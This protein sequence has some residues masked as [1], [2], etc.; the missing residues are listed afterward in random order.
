MKEYSFIHAFPPLPYFI[1]RRR[2]LQ[3][4]HRFWRDRNPRVMTISG[5]GGIGKTALVSQFI[6]RITRGE[7]ERP[8]G[9]FVWSFYAES[10]DD[11]FLHKL[12]DYVTEDKTNINHINLMPLLLDALTSSGHILIILDGLENIQ[13]NQGERYGVLKSSMM[14]HLLHKIA[15]GIGDTQCLITSRYHLNLSNESHQKSVQLNPLSMVESLK[16]L[17]QSDLK[18]SQEDF[19]SLISRSGGHPLTLQLITTYIKSYTDGDIHRANELDFFKD[20]EKLPT[21][22]ILF[23]VLRNVEQD[24]SIQESAILVR[25]SLFRHGATVHDLFTL[26]SQSD[27]SLIAGPLAG[28]EEW[29]ISKI[30]HKLEMLSLLNV[31]SEGLCIV[32]PIVKDYFIRFFQQDE[33][34]NLNNLA[35]ALIP[36]PVSPISPQ[37]TEFILEIIYELTLKRN[38]SLNEIRNLS[39]RLD[40]KE[41]PTVR[42]YSA[43]LDSAL[44]LRPGTPENKN[45]KPTAPQVF[46]SYVRQDQ[47]LV[48]KLR[49]NLE[50]NNIHVWQDIDR[51][52]PG[53]RWK[54]EIRKAIKNGDFFVACFSDNYWSRDRTY[55][56]EELLIAI[57]E[58][59]LRPTDTSWFIPILL[60]PCEVPDKPISN[61]ETLRDL[62][63]IEI[64]HNW[65][66]SIRLLVQIFKK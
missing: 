58:L 38:L 56:N 62:Q 11:V 45:I 57:E 12:Y 60:S 55:M 61:N 7:Y 24:L 25:I 36:A 59:R 51:I 39:N 23:Q 2:E 3:Q 6:N 32:H 1:G 53:R 30:I 5:L 29:E 8:D 16:F 20:T 27:D 44:S 4:L 22:H 31:S 33:T 19:K 41:S 28:L 63:H 13:Q 49:N 14:N 10:D 50:E 37:V 65:D 64:Y 17:Y 21:Q 42:V 34:F 47:D 54:E 35:E 26:F 40:R 43:L 15:H 52:I 66:K 9:L 18:G 48:E 46:I